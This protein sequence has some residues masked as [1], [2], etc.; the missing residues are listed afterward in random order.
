MD[1]NQLRNLMAPMKR[2][3]KI[4]LPHV[5]YYLGV[6]FSDDGVFSLNSVSK[7]GSSNSYSGGYKSLSDFTNQIMYYYDPKPGHV[8]QHLNGNIYE[9]LHIANE[10]S[11]RDDYPPTVVYKGANGN[12]WVKPLTNF[13]RKMTRIK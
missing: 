10:Y 5:G 3:D 11:L 9:V 12:V 1:Y 13:M 8:Y 7:D 6:T 4:T 2:G